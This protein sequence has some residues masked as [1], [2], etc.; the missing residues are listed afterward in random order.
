MSIKYWVN[1]KKKIL[2]FLENSPT[3]N[4][5]LSL[6]FYTGI[7]Y[8][9]IYIFVKDSSVLDIQSKID[10]FSMRIY[11]EEPFKNY[12]AVLSQLNTFL[13]GNREQYSF[14]FNSFSWDNPSPAVSRYKS[15]E[16]TENIIEA[17]DISVRIDDFIN[18]YAHSP[19]RTCWFNYQNWYHTI[20]LRGLS[21]IEMV[22]IVR[23]VLVMRLILCSYEY[24]LPTAYV[25]CLN[26]QIAA[27][28]WLDY[29]EGINF[30]FAYQCGTNYM[31]RYVDKE[32]DFPFYDKITEGIDRRVG[33]DYFKYPV[34]DWSWGRVFPG[35]SE[36]FKHICDYFLSVYTYTPNHAPGRIRPFFTGN[37][38]L[39][40]VYQDFIGVIVQ[41][42]SK[43]QEARVIVDD[44]F[45]SY[46]QHDIDPVSLLVVKFGFFEVNPILSN[47]HLLIW[48]LLGPLFSIV[49]VEVWYKI[50]IVMVYALAIRRLKPL[51][52][53]LIRWHFTTTFICQQATAGMLMLF[54]RYVL[55]ETSFYHENILTRMHWLENDVTPA[56]SSK[57]VLEAVVSLQNDIVLD[58][59]YHTSITSVICVCNMALFLA[60][61]HAACGQYFY[62]PWL[63]VNIEMHTGPRGK[64]SIY[65]GGL[66]D[67]QKYDYKDR[68]YFWY[69]MFGRGRDNKSILSIVFDFIKNLFV[70]FFKTVLSFFKNN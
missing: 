60:A 65:S 29:L 52:S 14:A 35:E 8:I 51:T 2:N 46:V 42:F 64:A 36:Y 21:Q 24:N 17:E 18:L 67:W 7:L 53:Y 10:L 70:K 38:R 68:K 49:M 57:L 1:A 22:L 41:F 30:M 61:L 11:D 4:T 59:L 20:M 56:T 19:L 45:I 6:V 23:F 12:D 66:M 58:I 39:I 15:L 16:Y 63:T 9:I 62:V 48:H 44:T 5:P 25:I 33:N 54:G 32:Y 69:G 55:G 50:F 34:R 13:N 27:T 43:L 28:F 37:Q 31:A 40:A 47:I 3:L 26:G